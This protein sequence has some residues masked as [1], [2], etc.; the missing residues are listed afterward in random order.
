MSAARTVT[1]RWCG[2]VASAAAVVC[3]AATPARAAINADFNGDG[4]P[5]RIVLPRPPETN[6]VVRISG[7]APQVLKFPGHLLSIVAADVDHD[8]RLDLSALSEHRGVFVWLNKGGH[9][10]FK[11]LKRKLHRHTLSLENDGP[12]ASAPQRRDDKPF[13]QGVQNDRDRAAKSGPRHGHVLRAIWKAGFCC[14]GSLRV[15]ASL[16]LV[17]RTSCRPPQ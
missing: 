2:M 6:I 17:S 7:A 3:F 16:G 5:D 15:K 10:R 13:T 1:R 14:A 4:V 12:L 11:A 9:G 8:G